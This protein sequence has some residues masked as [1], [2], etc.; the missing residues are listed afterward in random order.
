[1]TTGAGSLYTQL[2]KMQT[3]ISKYPRERILSGFAAVKIPALGPGDRTIPLPDIDTAK[4]I[5]EFANSYFH[6][7][8]GMPEVRRKALNDARARLI[9]NET[10]SGE[11]M[12]LLT[13]E[14]G[15]NINFSL[16]WQGGPEERQVVKL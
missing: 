11:E 13:E 2:K 15:K 6:L 12:D 9:A 10:L 14:N 3:A 7:T 5:V 1:M 16:L 8:E 4:L